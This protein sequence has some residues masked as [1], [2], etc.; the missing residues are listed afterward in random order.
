MLHNP[1]LE[2]ISLLE[3]REEHP[4]SLYKENFQHIDA[5]DM[6]PMKHK[7]NFNGSINITATISVTE[8]DVDEI[9][10]YAHRQLSF[11]IDRGSIDNVIEIRKEIKFKNSN[12]EGTIN[13]WDVLPTGKTR[14]GK[15]NRNLYSYDRAKWNLLMGH[16]GRKLPAILYFP[17]FLFEFPQRIYLTETE[18]ET[19]TNAYYRLIVQDILDSVDNGLTVEQHIVNR[20]RVD[21]PSSRGALEAVLLKMGA[22]VSRTIFGAWNDMFGREFPK[23]EITVRYYTENDQDSEGEPEVYIEFSIR[24]S[25]AMYPITERSLGFRWFFC[26]MLF[27]QFRQYRRGQSNTLFLFDEPASNLHSRAQ[28]QLLRSFEAI[29]N[30]DR[31]RIIYSTHSHHMINPR[32][33]ENTFIVTNEGVYDNDESMYEYSSHDTN[34]QIALYREF[35]SRHPTKTTYFQPILNTLEYFPSALEMISDAVF[36]EGKNDYYMIKYFEE[37]ILNRRSSISII[38]GSSASGF[39]TLIS[40][41]LGWGRRFVLLLDDDNEGRENRERYILQWNLRPTQVITLAEFSQKWAG[42]ELEDLLTRTDVRNIRAQ[43]YPATKSNELSKKEIARALQEK[44]INRDATGI[45]KHAAS[46]FEALIVGLVDRLA[47][48]D[49]Q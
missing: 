12:Y 17:T 24:E 21:T 32:W 38:P 13:V 43:F 16:I 10:Q 27:T 3:T 47:K 23:R 30:E 40:L 9:V 39:D 26:F 6:I 45:T 5:N 8:S 1:L 31:G 28:E 15:I 18:N 14:A 49:D 36:V 48:Y 44:L 37:V 35:V 25:E 29:T 11:E 22:T 41:Y 7:A 42:F 33:L 4:A 2:A 19:Q 20:A 46:A 34:V